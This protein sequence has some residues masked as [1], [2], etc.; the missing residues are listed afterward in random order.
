MSMHAGPVPTWQ[1]SMDPLPHALS[2]QAGVGGGGQITKP[3]PPVPP[4][5]PLAP[6]A[7]T[8]PKPAPPSGGGGGG[9][10]SP[11]APAR[12]PPARPARPAVT[13]PAPT[14]EGSVPV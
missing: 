1:V 14:P 8:S 9:P 10:V 7:P 2:P 11:P 6:A 4:K 12:P 5:P 3:D 13:G